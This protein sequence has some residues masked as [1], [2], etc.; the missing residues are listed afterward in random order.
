MSLFTPDIW[1]PEFVDFN[2]QLLNRLT[3]LADS[4]VSNIIVAIF[5]TAQIIACGYTAMTHMTFRR[6][7][8]QKKYC[9]GDI[10]KQVSIGWCCVSVALA[11]LYT[12]AAITYWIGFG[13]RYQSVAKLGGYF[14]TEAESVRWF[15][16]HPDHEGV[17]VIC[18]PG[19]FTPLGSDQ[20][21]LGHR[22]RYTKTVLAY[23][24]VELLFASFVEAMILLADGV[25]IYRF[26]VISPLKKWA[27][28]AT[29]VLGMLTLGT[30]T[31]LLHTRAC[32]SH[33]R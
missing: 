7:C 5:C 3:W 32:S 10:Q 21:R 14:E 6:R 31:S 29:S 8:Y 22:F 15:H 20:T 11:V 27:T 23:K 26:Y 17:K 19:L 28:Y 4:N 33:S 25:L 18:A 13:Q 2:A 30:F 24:V 9:G 16:G 1:F 12:G